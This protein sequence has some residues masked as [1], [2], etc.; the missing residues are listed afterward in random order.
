[1][2]LIATLVAGV[3][4]WRDRNAFNPSPAIDQAEL[5]RL[6]ARPLILPFI[7]SEG[8]CPGRYDMVTYFGANPH[9]DMFGGPVNLNSKGLEASAAGLAMQATTRW[10]DYYDLNYSVERKLLKGIVLI[11]ARDLKTGQA[12]VFIGPHAAGDTFGTDAIDGKTV[13]Q[14][15]YAILDLSHPP[16]NS[17]NYFGIWNVRQG[18]PA[19]WSGCL[20]LQLDGPDYSQ[21]VAVTAPPRAN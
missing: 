18:M 20:G 7:A 14:F 13:E 19:G 8:E 11:R 5:A 9:T 17:G 6:Q 12:G 10:G 4:V 3:R 16:A 1:V 21:V 2:L 15:G